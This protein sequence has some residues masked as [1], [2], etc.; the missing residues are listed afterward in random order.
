MVV[1]CFQNCSD[2]L[3]EKSFYWTRKTFEIGGWRPR[4]CKNFEITRTIYS[5]SESPGGFSDLIYL[6]GQIKLKLENNICIYKPAGNLRK[7]FVYLN[8]KT[9]SLISISWMLD[10]LESHVRHKSIWFWFSLEAVH[11]K[12][13]LILIS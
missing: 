8:L 3:W 12:I 4:I 2:L 5:N 7:L 13:S 11:F 9:N 10:I 6:L 1:F